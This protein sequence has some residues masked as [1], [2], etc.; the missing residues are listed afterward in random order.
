MNE[1]PTSIAA[2]QCQSDVQME[3]IVADDASPDAT[4]ALMERYPDVVYRRLEQNGGPSAARNAAIDAATGDWI[5]VLD[6]DDTMTPGRL[7]AMI[8]LAEEKDAD[9]LLGN[10]RRVDDRGE[11]I[12]D[13]PYLDP[14][15]LDTDTP[16][17]AEDYVG[18]NQL[19]P[20]TQD[21]GYLK[22]IFRR[23][24]LNRHGIRYDVALRNSEDYH[25]ILAAI[26]A[27]ARVFVA[28]QPD[29]LYRVA[30]GSISHIVAPHIYQALMEADRAF[31]ASLGPDAPAGLRRLLASRKHNLSMLM[32]SEEV[33]FALKSRRPDRAAMALLRYPPSAMRVLSQLREAAGKRMGASTASDAPAS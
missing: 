11:P 27:G 17:S 29:Y 24:F 9:I 13:A 30:E 8:A 20:G 15:A 5:A 21:W 23:D 16:L 28:P 10:F 12:D 31:A 19:A 32:H 26:M 25:I 1:L 18:H 3:I 33:M 4:P 14:A 7:A 2:A 22:P 6:A